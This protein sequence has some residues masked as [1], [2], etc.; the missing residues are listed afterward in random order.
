ML[1]Y[2][3]YSNLSTNLSVDN[4]GYKNHIA[5]TNKA[6]SFFPILKFFVFFSSLIALV[7]SPVLSMI[8]PKRD[9]KWA[10]KTEVTKSKC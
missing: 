7:V 8:N 1:N 9:S 6:F 3:T 2:F 4:H 5:M 10:T